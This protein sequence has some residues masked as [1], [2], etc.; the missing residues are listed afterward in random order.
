MWCSTVVGDG[1]R[2][3]P[4]LLHRHRPGRRC[5]A[6]RGRRVGAGR[7]T[8]APRAGDT[9]PATRVG[10]AVLRAAVGDRPGA[11]TREPVAI[12]PPRR[13]DDDGREPVWPGV[14]RPRRTGVQGR[15][16]AL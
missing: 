11:G 15:L 12:G 10:R 16:L 8:G 1:A 4:R 5:A 14:P 6:T 7:W 9:Q 13:V 3:R 2:A